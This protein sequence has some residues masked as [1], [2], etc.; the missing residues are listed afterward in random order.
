M[1]S[2]NLHTKVYCENCG[3]LLLH[4]IVPNLV[5]LKHFLKIEIEPCPDCLQGAFE[6]GQADGQDPC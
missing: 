2:K 4:H 6:A 3:R 1:S 5:D